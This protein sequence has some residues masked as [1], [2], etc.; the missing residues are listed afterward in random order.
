MDFPTP[1]LLLNNEIIFISVPPKAKSKG[2]FLNSFTEPECYISW[3]CLIIYYSINRHYFPLFPPTTSLSFLDLP[4]I[5]ESLLPFHAITSFLISP[6]IMGF[7]I[8]RL[9]LK[10]N[11][12]GAF[13]SKIS[14]LLTN[15]SRKST[16]FSI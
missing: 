5:E 7:C 11:V 6:K 15:H 14:I 9:R 16:L 10:L 2:Y 4:S 8:I 12:F 1:P 13:I 3:I